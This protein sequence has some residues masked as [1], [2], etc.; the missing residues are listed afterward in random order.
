MRVIRAREYRRKPWKNGGGETIE[1]AVGPADATLVMFDWRVSMAHI[2]ADGPFSD[3]PGIDRTLGILE[4]DGITLSIEGRERRTLTPR[5]APYSF[6]GDVATHASLIGGTVT[7]LNVMTRRGLLQHRVRRMRIDDSLELALRAPTALL[8][9]IAG[10]VRIEAG[11]EALALGPLD[12]LLVDQPY[13]SARI[14][15]DA[16]SV[17]FLIEVEPATVLS[18]PEEAIE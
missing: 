14:V 10:T 15:S 6:P 11:K 16:T 7:D 17:V 9:C 12:T 13:E 2:E 3:F 5:S 1:V 8:F 18:T 4:G